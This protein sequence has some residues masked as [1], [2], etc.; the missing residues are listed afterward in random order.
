M[1]KTLTHPA[2]ELPVHPTKRHPLTG[3]LLRAVGV[4]PDGKVVWPILGGDDTTPPIERPEGVTE[5]EWEALGDPG[6]KAIAREREAR[7]QA[8][9]ERD[10]AR[11]RPAPPKKNTAPIPTTSSCTS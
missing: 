1:S 6:K 11:A 10:A 2:L 7:V 8:E 9:R 3:A 5:E 4:M